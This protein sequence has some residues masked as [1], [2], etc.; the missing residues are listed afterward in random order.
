MHTLIQPAAAA[1][2]IHFAKSAYCW[3]PNCPPDRN[4]FVSFEQR[5]QLDQPGPATLHLFADSRYRLW[6][7]EVFVA[8]GPGRFVTSS[9]EYDSHDLAPWLQ[10][11]SNLIRVEVNFYGASSFQTMPDGSPGFI[12][13]GGVEDSEVSFTTPGNWRARVHHAWKADAPLF[14]FAQNPA[15]ICDT[16]ILAAELAIPAE[17]P[18]AA[19]GAEA[20]PWAR[21]TP[22]NVPMPDYAAVR[23]ARLL[24]AGPLQEVLRWGMQFITPGS[25]EAATESTHTHSQ[26]STWI[27]SPCAQNVMLD[28][29]WSELTLNGKPLTIEYPANL[30]NHGEAAVELREGWNFLSGH[31]ARLLNQWSYLLGLPTDAGSSLHAEPSLACTYAFACSPPCLDPSHLLCPAT[32]A[33]YVIPDDWVLR[34]GSLDQITPARLVAWDYPAEAKTIRSQP[35]SEL[36]DASVFTARAALWSFDFEDEYF[37]HPVIEVEAPAGTVMDV[38]YDDWKRADGCVNLYHSNPFTDAADRFVLRGGRQKIEVLNPRGG[39]YLQVNLRAPA[40]SDPVELTV[41]DVSIRRRTTINTIEGGFTCGDPI[42]DWAWRISIHTLQAST[43][44][45]YSDCPWRER[46]S[47][48]GDS[49]V[50]FHLHRLASADLSVA[51]RTFAIFG[52]A[53]RADGQLACCAPSWHTQSHVDFTLIWIQAVRDFWAYTGDKAFLAEQ[54]PVIQRIWSSSTWQPGANGLWD[55]TSMSA[56]IDWGVLTSERRG[57]GNTVVNVLRVA[58]AKACAELADVLGLDEEKNRFTAEAEAVSSA[59]CAHLWN[60]KEGRFNASIGADTPAIHAN[61]LAL[62]YGIGPAG[63]ILSYLE[64]KLRANFQNGLKKG[65]FT[66]FAELYFF[67]YLIPALVAQ[68]RVEFAEELI[69]EH[70]GFLQTL[71]IPTLPECFNNAQTSGG[72]CC[73]SWSGTPAIHAT[74]SILGLRLAHPGQPDVWLLDPRSPLH[75]S[76]EGTLPHARGPIHVRWDRHDGKIQA[77]VI[78][79]AGITILPA[80]HVTVHRSFTPAS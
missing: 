50:N 34:S 44:E 25:G 39:I 36:A 14:S 12:A 8:Y 31:F 79:P 30:G 48:I 33:D 5:F 3:I 52:K 76:A 56:F 19:L 62:N 59:L 22:R 9:P 38:A 23:P 21:P 74:E 77:H 7:N 73:H 60:E 51:R 2:S 35:F 27:H 57:A 37:G 43:D 55:I 78:A 42:L 17:L 68:G 67:Y 40:G 66:G 28:C 11:G 47:Y 10:Y 16:R 18:L 32:P 75:L 71:G 69:R 6:V 58:A 24:V 54:W 63:K 1:K 41:H 61:I 49:L 4:Q 46:A 65:E 15:E 64:P 20:T 45:A 26:F 72:S 70:Y 80:A 13:D 29:F 53:Q